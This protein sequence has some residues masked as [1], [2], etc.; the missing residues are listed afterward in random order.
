L[1]NPQEVRRARRHPADAR[2]RWTDWDP[3]V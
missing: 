2:E 3:G 1:S